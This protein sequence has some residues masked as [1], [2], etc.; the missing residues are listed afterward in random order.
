MHIFDEHSIIITLLIIII[1]WLFYLTFREEPQPVQ[2]L[3]LEGFELSQ[4]AVKNIAAIYN[5][6]NLTVSNLTVTG[7]I[8]N[9]GLTNKVNSFQTQINGKQPKADDYVQYRD[10]FHI[11]NA[12]GSW[13]SFLDVCGGAH[14]GATEAHSDKY[15]VYTDTRK[16][17]DGSSGT[18]RLVKK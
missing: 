9:A 3:A 7:A 18:W 13:A 14:C 16:S 2:I 4:E 17:R 11:N 5:K 8:T 6:Q 12:Y 1:I 15:S 10:S